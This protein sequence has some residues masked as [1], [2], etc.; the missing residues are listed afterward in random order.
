MAIRRGS[1]GMMLAAVVCATAL[2]ALAQTQP[3]LSVLK[4]RWVRTDGG[5]V[6]EV[7][8]VDP[9]GRLDAAYYNPS[10]VN[11]AIAQATTSGQA[12]TVFIELRAPGY[13]GST[14]RLIHDPKSDTLQGI[15][16]QAAIQ[17]SFQVV[18]VRAK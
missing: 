9:S 4:G 7:K 16:Y 11:V 2:S 3:D 15:Y 1:A 17:Q 13:P 8:R 10:P 18:F 5:Y 6:I 14:Y 12:V